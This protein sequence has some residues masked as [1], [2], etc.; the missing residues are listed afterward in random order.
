MCRISTA[1]ND[2]EK[3]GQ[4]KDAGCTRYEVKIS[5]PQQQRGKA[6]VLSHN[7]TPGRFISRSYRQHK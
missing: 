7:W 2:P 6:L 4:G 1:K 5:E 3:I